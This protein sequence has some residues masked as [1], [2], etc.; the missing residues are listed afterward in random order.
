MSNQF[1]WGEEGGRERWMSRRPE[2]GTKAQ[3]AEG[4]K[5][6]EG[7]PSLLWGSKFYIA[8]LCILSTLG[9]QCRAKILD[10]R[11][12]NLDPVFYW[13]RAVARSI[14]HHRR[15]SPWASRDRRH[16]RAATTKLREHK[17]VPVSGTACRKRHQHHL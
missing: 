16:Y 1:F 5:S 6:V 14:P 17:L 12:D 2:R 9:Q 8:N 4:N 7:A 15:S 3:I 13:G 11:K 10:G